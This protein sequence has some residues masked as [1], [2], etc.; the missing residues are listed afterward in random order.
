VKKAERKELIRRIINEH[1][2]ET[3]EELVEL[4]K[5]EG[6]PVTQATVSRDIKELKLSKLLM[7]NG[8]FRYADINGSEFGQTSNLKSVFAEGYIRAEAAGNIVV[9]K[10]VV[11]MADACA[12]Y[13]DSLQR[14][15]VVG[16]LAGDD[17]VFV[18]A[19][20]PQDSGKLIRRL[21]EH[22]REKAEEPK[23]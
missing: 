21:E 15:E 4:L 20:T 11:G 16:S 9:I 3:Q 6:V 18:V 12:L 7:Q 19:R 22:L 17:T 8:K 14:Q 23:E 2:I 5:D 1:T 13:V 10:T